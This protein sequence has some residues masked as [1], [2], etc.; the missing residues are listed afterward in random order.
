MDSVVLRP[1]NL[2][3]PPHP[4]EQGLLCAQQSQARWC[5]PVI[6]TL[7]EAESG[8]LRVQPSPGHLVTEQDF[9]SRV[10]GKS[11]GWSSV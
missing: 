7:Y 9:V 3:Y 10:I 6:L 4:C 8:Q 5:T 2:P 1:Q 11:R